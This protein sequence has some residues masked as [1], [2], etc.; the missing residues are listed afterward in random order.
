MADG[1]VYFCSWCGAVWTEDSAMWEEPH[2][3]PRCNHEPE[4]KPEQRQAE[5]TQGG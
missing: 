2:S 1:D 4:D 5:Q 3:C